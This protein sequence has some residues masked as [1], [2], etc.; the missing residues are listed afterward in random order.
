MTPF[1]PAKVDD[2]CIVQHNVNL[3]RNIYTAIV[4]KIDD[5]GHVIEARNG[6]TILDSTV[7]TSS[8]VWIVEETTLTVEAFLSYRFDSVQQAYDTLRW[9][10]DGINDKGYKGGDKQNPKNR[11]FVGENKNRRPNKV[12]TEETVNEAN[13]DLFK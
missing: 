2:P 13:L 6:S 8:F 1:R 10:R 11:V 3:T 12:V 4:S 7:L 9:F 5:D